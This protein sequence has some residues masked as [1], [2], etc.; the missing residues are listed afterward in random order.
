MIQ[1]VFI[2]SLSRFYLVCKLWTGYYNGSFRAGIPE[3]HM[4]QKHEQKPK[5]KIRF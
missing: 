5:R 3:N 4:V 2:S 1:L